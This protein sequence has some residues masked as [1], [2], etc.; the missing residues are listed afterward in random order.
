MAS[1]PWR[2]WRDSGA[3]DCRQPQAL[4]GEW[5]EW[6]DLP[7]YCVGGFASIRDKREIPI[8]R[9]WDDAPLAP[10]MPITPRRQP[11]ELVPLEFHGSFLA[12]KPCGGGQRIDSI[13][14]VH[15]M[16]LPPT[17]SETP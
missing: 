7:T 17:K 4:S 1:K 12:A 11:I 15:E 6:R 2:E 16:R 9:N 8:G 13:A 5:R 3:T 10:L 14:A